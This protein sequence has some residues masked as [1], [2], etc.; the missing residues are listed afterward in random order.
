[1]PQTRFVTQ[2]A[3]ERG[4]KPI[5]VINKIDR[6][7]ARPDW[8]VDQTFD[9]FDR[10]GATD[11]QLDFS[12]VYASALNGYAGLTSDVQGGDMA[13]LFETI[14]NVVHAPDVDVNGSFQMQV[15]SLDYNS[16][17]G[18][19]GIGRI[20][21]GTVNTNTPV[22]IIDRDGN[23]RNARLLQIFGFLDGAR[24]SSA[25]QRRGHYSLYWNRSAG[26]LR[27]LMRSR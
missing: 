15:S 24:R 18:V 10:L 21:R 25:S 22:T 9:L 5:V 8:V 27:H 3:L 23:K 20:S 7:G 1:M 4:L 16:Y 17:V 11:E 14:V 6:P 19:I 2:K 13:P 26:Y 12:I